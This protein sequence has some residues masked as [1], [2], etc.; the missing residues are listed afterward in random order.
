MATKTPDR[1]QQ[2]RSETTTGQ[3]LDAAAELFGA[4]GYAAT[5][6]DDV[7]SRAGVTKGALYHHFASKRELFEA[8]FEREQRKIAVAASE[9]HGRNR[10]HWDGFYEGCRAFFEA[11]LDPAVQRITLLDAPS[12]LGWERMREIEGR[13]THALLRE[14]LERAMREG[15]I[16]RRPVEPLAAMLDGAICEAA[17]FVARSEDQRKVMRRALAELRLQLDALRT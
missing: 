7:V 6:L 5:H 11:S 16:A 3:L 17:M 10:N 4:D 12:V 14:G 8:V 9:A 2:Q 1:T 15:T 13:Y